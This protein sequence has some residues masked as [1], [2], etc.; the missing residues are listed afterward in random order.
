M[1]KDFEW[2]TGE[3]TEW[4][5]VS[6]QQLDGQTA[7]R[8]WFRRWGRL[9]GLTAVL[10]LIVGLVGYSFFNRQVEQVED[11]TTADILA[12]HRLVRQALDN[13]DFDLLS[14]LMSDDDANWNRLQLDLLNLDLVLN[15][16]PLG[17]KI[18]PGNDAAPDDEPTVTLSPDLQT[19]EVVERISY[20][21]TGGQHISETILLE[22]TFFYRRE[23][24]DNWQL[25]ALPYDRDFWG[26]W[27]SI[28]DGDYVNLVYSQREEATALFLERQLDS[29]TAQICE[30]GDIACPDGFKLEVRLAHEPSSLRMLNKPYFDIT[31][32]SNGGVYHLTFPSP[33]LVG[34]P[35]DE[36]GTEVL[37]HGYANWL[38]AILAFHY[39]DLQANLDEPLADKLA[40]WGLEKPPEPQQILPIPQRTS[41]PPIPFP[42]QDVILACPE[43]SGMTLLRYDPRANQWS[44]E[45]NGLKITSH[46]NPSQIFPGSV[47]ASLPEGRGVLLNLIQIDGETINSKIVSWQDG[48]ERLWL[49]RDSLVQLLQEPIR[50]QF[51]PTGRKIVFFDINY[52]KRDNDQSSLSTLYT[53]DQN[54][55]LSGQ[56]NPQFYDGFPYWSPDLS[57]L[58][59]N[60]LENQNQLLLRDEQTREETDLGNGFSPFWIDN[61]SFIYIRNVETPGAISETFPTVEIVSAS[62]DDPLNGTALVD[63]TDISAVITGGDSTVPVNIRSI[64]AHPDH[65]DWL[66][67]FAALQTEINPEI[68]YILSFQ[69]DTGQ[70]DVMMNLEDNSLAQPFRIVDDGRLLAAQTFGPTSTSGSLVLISLN[71]DQKTAAPQSEAEKITFFPGF[72]TDWSQDGR[73]LL[74]AEEDAFTLIAP[75]HNYTQ[76]ITH[77]ISSCF[78]AVWVNP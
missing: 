12:V 35:V 16:R 41:T 61:D 78:E 50:R 33:T 68:N 52:L 67:F 23:A 46:S 31:L 26:N 60:D 69:A 18:D 19:A 36:A 22:Q 25:T 64:A 1:S 45:L 66:F 34:R 13:K 75:G 15:R 76:T 4:E 71:P 21:V 77:D 65:P 14:T 5:G 70:L 56:C 48:Q 20:V 8:H 37:Y 24:D 39:I 2:K 58:L 44:D 17:L 55:C 3:E 63:S 10:L 49:E 29:L 74:I 47:M 59:L 51:D 53:L 62:V 42:E 32:A 57:W 6:G 54:D 38:G 7:F 40:A 27:E 30:D 72:G 11:A 73:W 9:L 43:S 28:E